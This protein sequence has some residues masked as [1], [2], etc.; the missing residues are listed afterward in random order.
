MHQLLSIY[1]IAQTSAGFCPIRSIAFYMLEVAD[2]EK[3]LYDR[4]KREP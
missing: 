1:I 3:K 2:K 4:A